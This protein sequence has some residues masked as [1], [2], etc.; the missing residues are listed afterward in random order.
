M[1]GVEKLHDALYYLY[2]A[3]HLLENDHYDYAH[4][5]IQSAI[6]IITDILN[7][8]ILDADQI[9]AFARIDIEKEY[10]V[11]NCERRGGDAGWEKWLKV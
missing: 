3:Q 6:N 7:L 11:K 10:G 5:A 9:R 2:G 1:R 4:D 8:S